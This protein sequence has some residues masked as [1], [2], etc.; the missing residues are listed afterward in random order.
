MNEK[1]WKKEGRSRAGF[2]LI[3]L[4]VVIAIIAILAALLLPALSAAKQRA[5]RTACM[6]NLKQI[7]IAMFVYAESSN[8]KLPSITTSSRGWAW[9]MPWKVG[10]TLLDTMSGDKK[11]FYCPGT[12]ARFSDELDFGNTN[13]GASLWYY[14]PGNYHVMGYCAAFHD[15]DPHNPVAKIDPEFQN[16]SM[17]PE[18]QRQRKDKVN[19]YLTYTL[20]PTTDRVLF[21]DA[22]IN[23]LADGKGSWTEVPGGFKV[24]GV[25]YPHTSAHMGSDGIPAGGNVEYKDGH[26]EWRKFSD[27]I[28]RTG[29]NTPSF[30]W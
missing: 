19:P 15:A 9:D 17:L 20:I 4:L 10:N 28:V 16:S 12:A 26:V 7:G 21:A 22:T 1:K 23:T 27:M 14:A 6:N 3:E 24:N 2:T 13:S 8:D 5:I 18:M 25:T 11:V 29:I 30:W